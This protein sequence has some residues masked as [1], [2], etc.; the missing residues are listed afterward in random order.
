MYAYF[1]PGFAHSKINQEKNRL[2]F[3]QSVAVSDCLFGT[4]LNN[5]LQIDFPTITPESI[6]VDLILI[7]LGCV[8]LQPL[9]CF[10][11]LVLIFIATTF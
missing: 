8:L 9:G 11:G 3:S 10:G 2:L 4:L 1:P 5:W 7:H 6:W